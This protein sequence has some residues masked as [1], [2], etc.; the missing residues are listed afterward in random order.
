MHSTEMPASVGVHGPGEMMIWS[1]F[2]AAISSHVIW[3]LRWT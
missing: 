1:G 3:S 2:S